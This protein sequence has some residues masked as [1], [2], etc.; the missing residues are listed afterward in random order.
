M[1]IG[2]NE[3]VVFFNDAATTE[4]NPPTQ[5]DPLPAE[6]WSN[7]GSA[8]QAKGDMG[9]AIRDYDRAI[10]LNP[11]YSMS[12]N[13]RGLARRANGYGDGAVGDYDRALE[14]NAH[15]AAARRL[16]APIFRKIVFT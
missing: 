16:G 6:A 3:D 2:P 15:N 7:R 4:N 9:G 13:N 14:P 11:K 1:H 8:R 5:I 10:E 12:W